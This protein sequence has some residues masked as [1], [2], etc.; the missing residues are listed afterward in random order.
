MCDPNPHPKFMVRVTFS[1]FLLYFS[2][3]LKDLCGIKQGFKLSMPPPLEHIESKNLN[4][5]CITEVIETTI[6]ALGTLKK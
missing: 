3:N 6:L 2:H 1:I 5:S 4:T